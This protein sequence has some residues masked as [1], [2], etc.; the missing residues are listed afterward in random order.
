MDGKTWE[1]RIEILKRKRPKVWPHTLWAGLW[2]SKIFPCC[3]WECQTIRMCSYLT[4]IT[5][6]TLIQ[7]TSKTNSIGKIWSGMHLKYQKV[8]NNLRC[9]SIEKWWNQVLI[10]T[11]KDEVVVKINEDALCIQIWS[12]SRLYCL[13][14]RKSTVQNHVYPRMPFRCK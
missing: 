8:G 6:V 14:K 1:N 10:H 13:I 5:L 11:L 12:S 2:K 4:K 9:P 3:W 7:P